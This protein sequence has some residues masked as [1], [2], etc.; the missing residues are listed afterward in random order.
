MSLTLALRPLLRLWRLQPRLCG[1]HGHWD[2]IDRLSRADQHHRHV[3]AETHCRS[4]IWSLDFDRLDPA[5][6]R[7]RNPV[8]E[9]VA[10]QE[11]QCGYFV[12]G[13]E[14]STAMPCSMCRG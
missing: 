9:S 1:L 3:L 7:R 12:P 4:G 2:P 13:G 14:Q 10:L 11:W 5:V 6:C 8:P